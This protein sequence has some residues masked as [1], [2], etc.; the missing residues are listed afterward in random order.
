MHGWIER[1]NCIS[2]LSGKKIWIDLKGRQL[3]VKSWGEVNYEAIELNHEID[4][5]YPAKV[6]FRENHEA[7]II[8]TRGNKIILDRIM[9][10]QKNIAKFQKTIVK[11]SKIIG[12]GREKWITQ[13]L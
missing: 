10:E 8:H 12:K 9:V 6:I 11:M 13:S 3:R 4:I 2:K 7:N 5:E 1:L